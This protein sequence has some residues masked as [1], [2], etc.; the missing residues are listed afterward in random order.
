M[1]QL[2]FFLLYLLHQ[3]FDI[4]CYSVNLYMM[5]MLYLGHRWPMRPIRILFRPA[6]LSMIL[7]EEKR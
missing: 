6:T 1:L 7:E 4:G 3:W 5:T 2:F